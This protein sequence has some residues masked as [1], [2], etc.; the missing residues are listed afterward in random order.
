MGFTNYYSSYVKGYAEVVAC[1]QEKLKVPR[2]IGKKGSKV[3]ITWTEK[4]IEAFEHIKK[5]LCGELILQRINPDKP[6]ILRVDASGYAIGACLEQLRDEQRVPTEDDSLQ[7]KTVPVAFLSRK[8]T[9]TQRRWVPREQETYAIVCALM[10]FDTIIGLQ[11]VVILSD[12]KTL[13]S[14]TKEVL[15]TPSGPV[16][17]RARWH[18]FFSRFNLSVGYTPGE[19]NTIADI[20]SRWAYPASQ[21]LKEVSKHGS[22]HD[23]EQ[24]IEIIRQE[25][26]EERSC[27]KIFVL[28]PP[29][30]EPNFYSVRSL[31]GKGSIPSL[32]GDSIQPLPSL[33]S[34]EG[35][36]LLLL[37]LKL[38][39]SCL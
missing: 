21:A 24:A 1:M 3:K 12:H 36:L 27:M 19:T 7:K 29:E 30:N 16:G 18:E 39:L 11:P 6:F 13:E 23:T 2:D 10:K 15:D 37:R 34:S 38:L 25:R 4:D 22:F 20:L 9:D 31:T 5:L 28:R 8:L 26:E 32:C 17:R 14:W 35:G 33:H